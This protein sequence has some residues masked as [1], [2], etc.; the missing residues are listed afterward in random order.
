[1]SLPQNISKEDV[2]ACAALFNSDPELVRKL[3]DYPDPISRIAK[4]CIEAGQVV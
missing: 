1:M 2:N 3:C 4:L